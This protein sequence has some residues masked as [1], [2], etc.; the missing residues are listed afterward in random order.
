[1]WDKATK[2]QIVD[3][4]CQVIS[5]KA[6]VW[7]A[8]GCPRPDAAATLREVIK[9]Q[10]HFIFI[11]KIIKFYQS[12]VEKFKEYGMEISIHFTLTLIVDLV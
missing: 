9:H 7:R 12:F 3:P 1:M 5:F 8:G 2:S 6:A 4:F 10:S 11:I